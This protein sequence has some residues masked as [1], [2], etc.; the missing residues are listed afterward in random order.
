MKTAMGW[1]RDRKLQ[2]RLQIKSIID[3]ERTISRCFSPSLNVS[4]P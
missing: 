1:S 2:N 3:E 4:N